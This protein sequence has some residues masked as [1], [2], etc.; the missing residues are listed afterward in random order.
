MYFRIP[1][2]GL[3]VSTNH[4]CKLCESGIKGRQKIRE[5]IQIYPILLQFCN[6]FTNSYENNI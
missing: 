1:R 6:Y 5:N 2:G 4:E 3:N